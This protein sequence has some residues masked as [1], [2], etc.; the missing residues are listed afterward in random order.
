MDGTQSLG[1]LQFDV[2]AVQPDMLAVDRYKWLLAP[3]GATFFYIS[4][5]LRRHSA[6]DRIGWR[7]DGLALR[8]RTES[9]RP[10]SF[11]EAAE[12]YEGGMLNFPS[13]YGHGRIRSA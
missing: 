2:A 3:N 11:P 10:R 8:G 5:A 1:A 13:L 6:A 9:R 12:R 7:S 4:P